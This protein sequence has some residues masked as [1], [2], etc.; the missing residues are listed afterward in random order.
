MKALSEGLAARGHD[1]TV[2]TAN[3]GNSMDLFRGIHGG[4]TKAEVINGVNVVRFN[5]K[6]TNSG[7][8]AE[9]MVSASWGVAVSPDSLRRGWNGHAGGARRV[10]V[11]G[12]GC[13]RT[14]LLSE[15]E[16]RFEHATGSEV[17]QLWDSSLGD[18]K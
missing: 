2:L 11:G 14:G 6:R 10:E 12:V 5:P 15:S 16:P 3:A 4:L 8:M 9:A 17:R 7:C 1:V 13:I 18:R